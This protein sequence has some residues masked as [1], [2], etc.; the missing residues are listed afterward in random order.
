MSVNRAIL[1]QQRRPSIQQF[2]EN[3]NVG[4]SGM[5]GRQKYELDRLITQTAAELP[6]ERRCLADSFVNNDPFDTFHDSIAFSCQPRSSEL[7]R[8][9]Y[10]QIRKVFGFGDRQSPVARY[11]PSA[12]FDPPVRLD[13]IHD[14]QV[15]CPMNR[16]GVGARSL[17]IELQAAL[18]PAGEPNTHFGSSSQNEGQIAGQRFRIATK[19]RPA[20][21]AN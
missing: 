12:L 5:L 10:D 21:N 4:N 1:S 20:M 2:I 6:R 15:R 19:R 18:N 17:N 7:R 11:R 16:G 14:V 8:L 13:P 3:L 9:S